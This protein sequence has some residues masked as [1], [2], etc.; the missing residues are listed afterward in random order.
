MLNKIKVENNNYEIVSQA[1]E[2][3]QP[4]LVYIWSLRGISLSPINA[5]DD[6]KV[7]KIFEIGDFWMK[8]FIRQEKSFKIK[9]FIK[10]LLP[11]TH[12]KKV[13][14][15][16]TICVSQWVADEMKTKYNAKNNYVFPNATAVPEALTNKQD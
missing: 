4:D 6:K 1:I 13:T 14:I 15:E 16:P 12:T 3:F 9:Q 10:S 2:E 11:F 8:G 7:P 5:I